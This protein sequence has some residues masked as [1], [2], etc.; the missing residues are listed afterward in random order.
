MTE[1][2]SKQPAPSKP[3]P[4]YDTWTVD[5]IAAWAATAGDK[6]REAA[7]AYEAAHQN[8]PQA[9]EAL[10]ATPEE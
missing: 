9:L 1:Q 8:R 5:Q 3:A 4:E 2:T 7:I 6:A 10:G